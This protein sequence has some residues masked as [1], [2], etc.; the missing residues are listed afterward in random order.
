MTQP[1][2]G[3]YTPEPYRP[4]PVNTS[5][6]GPK[7]VTFIGVG[8]LVLTVVIVAFMIWAFTRLSAD[9]DT[10]FYWWLGISG[11][12]FAI[13][14]AILLGLTGLGLT[15]GGSIMWA[16]RAQA[17]RVYGTQADHPGPPP[18]GYPPY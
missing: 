2:Q 9:V 18:G 10:E 4:L 13:P 6:T 12:A 17:R 11:A 7:V 3:P 8:C 5:T 1:W 16:V 14:A 15:I